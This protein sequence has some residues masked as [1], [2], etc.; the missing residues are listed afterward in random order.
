MDHSALVSGEHRNSKKFSHSKGASLREPLSRLLLKS[1]SVELA[2]CEP[3]VNTYASSSA[4]MSGAK[5]EDLLEGAD[6]RQI[7][8]TPTDWS[9]ARKKTLARS[10]REAS[11]LMPMLI[12][13]EP[14]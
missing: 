12:Q 2:G 9:A 4:L 7:E 5:A 3:P 10:K 11:A 14:V 1:Q 8:P 13:R 6:Q